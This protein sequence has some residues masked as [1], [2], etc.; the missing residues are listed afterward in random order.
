M[1]IGPTKAKTFRQLNLD[2]PI[3]FCVT[4]GRHSRA[5]HLDLTVGVSHGAG[6]FRKGGRRQD[7]V[8]IVRCLGDKDILHNQV[9]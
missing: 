4:G 5:A 2:P 3:L 8:S 9:A 1:G 6:F 7:H